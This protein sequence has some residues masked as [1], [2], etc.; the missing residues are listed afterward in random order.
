MSGCLSFCPASHCG[1]T[2]AGVVGLIQLTVRLSDLA[3]A[4]AVGIF[5]DRCPTP[6]GKRIPLVLV[7]KWWILYEKRKPL[8]SSRELF[9]PCR[10]IAML[11]RWDPLV[12][13]ST[14]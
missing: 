8:R 7:G 2:P 3:V 4:A 11:D 12:D 13:R 10:R 1:P 9:C 5:S 6:L 14:S